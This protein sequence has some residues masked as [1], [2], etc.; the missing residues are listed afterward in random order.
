MSL[1]KI[2]KDWVTLYTAKG[3]RI[4]D[5]KQILDDIWFDDKK[6]V[7]L[8]QH[9][10]AYEWQQKWPDGLPALLQMRSVWVSIGNI[11]EDRQDDAIQYLDK[12]LENYT[13]PAREWVEP[14]TTKGKI[15]W[16]LPIYDAH[17]WKLD[18]KGTS[19]NKQ[20]KKIWKWAKQSMDRLE[21]RWIDKMLQVR[22]WDTDNT[23][24]DGKTTKGTQQEHNAKSIDVY[25]AVN[26]LQ[27]ELTEYGANIAETFVAIL[28]WNHDTE[29]A[30]YHRHML[31]HLYQ[32][33]PNIKIMQHDTD[34]TVFKHWTVW[35]LLDHWDKLRPQHIMQEIN[36]HLSGVKYYER[37]SGHSH[38]TF[39]VDYNGAKHRGM[40][41][42][43]PL[44]KRVNDNWVGKNYNEITPI[45]YDEKW[46]IETFTTRL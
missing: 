38:Y 2:V 17:I 3:T 28:P 19:L 27:M 26:D 12:Y 43:W 45:I 33:H 35:L 5:P 20:V 34:H 36:K 10:K 37:L 29:K 18:M 11:L 16:L 4:T 14:M 13:P 39:Y 44:S 30:L 1:N 46:P 42:S 21:D 24:H 22:W 31:D 8:K 9:A 15:L 6:Q 41:S 23:D 7:V 32:N 40:P 25:K